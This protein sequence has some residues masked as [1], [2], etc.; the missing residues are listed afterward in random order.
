MDMQVVEEQMDPSSPTVC[1]HYKTL[2]PSV[3]CILQYI[4]LSATLPFKGLGSVYFIQRRHNKLIK[5]GV[6]TQI[7]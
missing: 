6:K 1:L 5:S 3:Y 2:I 7:L 4:F